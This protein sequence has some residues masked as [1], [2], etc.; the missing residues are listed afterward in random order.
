MNNIIFSICAAAIITA[1][2]RTLIPDERMGKQVNMVVSCF[3][4]VTVMNLVADIDFLSTFHNILE[5][6]MNY[7][8]YSVIYEMQTADETA[9]ILRSRL[10]KE[11]EKENI[12]PEKIYI[13]INI[14]K[15]KS[16]SISKIRLVFPNKDSF[17]AERAVEITTE[18]TGNEIEVSAEEW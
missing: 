9:N 10:Y 18:Y 16:I 6:D 15:S 12:N 5:M 13:D 3:F 11:L 2:F 17:E 7:N 1:V 8:D 14:S 4:L